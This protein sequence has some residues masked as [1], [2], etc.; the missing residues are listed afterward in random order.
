MTIFGKL[1]KLLSPEKLA[2]IAFTLVV[3]KLWTPLLS[4]DWYIYL[5]IGLFFAIK[6]IGV[7]FFG[8]KK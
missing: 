5:I 3:A 6:P 8:L 7:L 4:L 2:V 1:D